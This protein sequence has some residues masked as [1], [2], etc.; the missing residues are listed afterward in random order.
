MHYS[1]D[2][3][4]RKHFITAGRGSAFTSATCPAMAIIFRKFQT[5][6]EKS[7]REF[8][9]LFSSLWSLGGSNP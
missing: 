7:L 4:S 2:A 8:C 5:K 6:K 1:S 9:R 3:H